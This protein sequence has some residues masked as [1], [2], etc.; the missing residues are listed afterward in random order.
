MAVYWIT[1]R[2]EEVALAAAAAALPPGPATLTE[3][4]GSDEAR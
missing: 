3:K 2:R 4:G 1:H